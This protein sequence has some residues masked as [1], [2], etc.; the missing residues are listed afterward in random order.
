MPVEAC[1][2]DVLF[3]GLERVID[4]EGFDFLVAGMT[5]VPL[6]VRVGTAGRS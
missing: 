1:D 5:L 4:A 3:E 2:L 6:P